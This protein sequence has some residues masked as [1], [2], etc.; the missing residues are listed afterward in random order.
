MR[1]NPDGRSSTRPPLHEFYQAGQAIANEGGNQVRQP[2]VG[3]V[4]E[5]ISNASGHHQASPPGRRHLSGTCRGLVKATR[6][7]QWA[8]NVLVPAAPVAA[9]LIFHRV[10]FWHTIVA[11]VAF[12]AC[13]A[14]SYLINDAADVASDRRHPTK[15]S[16]PI[17]AGIVSVGLA[18][19]VGT[20]LMLSA[21]GLGGLLASWELSAV[22]V[23]YVLLTCSYSN[24]LKHI[25]VIELL[26]VA[27]G[28][29]LRPIAGAAA[30]HVPTSEWF[31]I[32]ATFGSLYVVVGK[33]YAEVIELGAHA[34]HA[35]RILSEYPPA[36]LRQTRDIC[37][38]VVLLAY[39]LWAFERQR[40]HGVPWSQLSIIPVTF[41]LF[42]YGLLLE[43]GQG[44]AP[45]ETILKDRPLLW[46]GVVFAV[47]FGLSVANA[48]R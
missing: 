29:L 2:L 21:V 18:Q 20:L 45:E 14:G 25:A 36:Y 38:S 47:L 1:S 30:T 15:R 19:T 39:C 27:A 17:A 12:T 6:P 22:L 8:K 5:A 37:T 31:L 28:F 43:R 13:A 16:R 32:V 4:P 34:T 35:R 41:G 23:A 46:A 40:L 42:R 11:I 48:T 10:V 9:G 33:R 24:W 3:E 7:K 44:G 26:S